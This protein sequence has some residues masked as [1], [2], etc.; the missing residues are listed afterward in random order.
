MVRY[1]YCY[2]FFAD[3]MEMQ[4]TVFV[5]GILLYFST[6]YL[7]EPRGIARARKRRSS[8]SHSDRN[9]LT[10]AIMHIAWA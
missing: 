4:P 9:R 6:I 2:M 7:V 3:G 10:F 5:F 8:T 1:P